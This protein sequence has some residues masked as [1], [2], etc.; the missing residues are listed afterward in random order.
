[1]VIVVV[2][3]VVVGVVRIGVGVS[4]EEVRKLLGLL[5]VGGLGRLA[6]RM[7][8]LQSQCLFFFRPLTLGPLTRGFP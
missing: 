3:V 7:D 1:M 5:L 6:V 8:G 4:R 2:V